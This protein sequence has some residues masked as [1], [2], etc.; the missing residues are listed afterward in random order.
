M[1]RNYPVYDDDQHQPLTWVQGRPLYATHL[2]VVGLA[3][4][5]L[6]TSV[7]LA[8]R[9]L[10]V[11]TALSFDGA[12]LLSGEAWRVISYGL[13]NRPSLSIAID[14]LLLF[15]FG[16]EVEKHLGRRSFLRLYLFIYLVP[17]LLLSALAY[18]F[19]LSLAGQTGALAIFVAFAA[20]YPSAP[21]VLNVPAGIAAAV[22]VAVF[23]L[24][25]LSYHDWAGLL[26]LWSTS[27]YALA[28][29]RHGQGRLSV[30]L[31]RLRAPFPRPEAPALR[32]SAAPSARPAPSRG[33]SGARPSVQD[34]MAEVDALLDK[35]SRSGLESLTT[36]EHQRLAAAQARLARRLERPSTRS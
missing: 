18:W 1:S 15:W 36:A 33:P 17:P 28:F 12:A 31:P 16:R 23:T 29:I 4:T 24:V 14:L 3:I 25:H 30:S 19:P 7:L 11:L 9:S 35:I 13:V 2:I 26:A 5:I 20:L 27:A 10:G 6:A 32:S 21:V 22:L 8:T 34:E